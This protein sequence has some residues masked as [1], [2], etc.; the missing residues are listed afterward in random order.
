MRTEKQKQK[1]EIE[2]LTAKIK[3][4][5]RLTTK[6]GFFRYYFELLKNSKTKEQAFNKVNDLYCKLFGVNRFNSFLEFSKM[7]KA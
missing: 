6:E 4:M 2:K 3:L 1:K 5:K 7:V